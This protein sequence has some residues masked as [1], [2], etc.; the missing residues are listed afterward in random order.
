MQRDLF[1]TEQEALNLIEKRKRLLGESW[2]EVLKEEFNKPYLQKISMYIAERRAVSVVY[3]TPENVFKAYQV[4]P[5]DKVKVILISQDPYNDGTATGIA[6][7]T[8]GYLEYPKTIDVL[9]K[10]VEEDVY[11]GL[12]F[13][14]LDPSIS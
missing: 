5:Y 11:D 9:D 1:K 3:P 6:M 4:T 13:P 7:G 10:A 12:R 8:N 14:P 2:Y